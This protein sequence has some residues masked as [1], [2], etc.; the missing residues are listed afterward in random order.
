MPA[1]HPLV[2]H[3]EVRLGVAEHV[4]DVQRAG[5]RGGRGVD[6]VNVLPRLLGVVVVDAACHP[7]LLPVLLA[8]KSAVALGQV[9][10]ACNRFRVFHV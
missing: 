6:A 1:A 4:A 10:D 9:V 3:R 7:V 5:D 8:L 2:A